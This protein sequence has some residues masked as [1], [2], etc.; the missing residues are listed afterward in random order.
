ML[1]KKSGLTYEDIRERYEHFRARCLKP[2]RKTVKYYNSSKKMMSMGKLEKGCTVPLY[3]EKSKC[4][5]K[6]VPDNTE[7]ESL[8]IDKRCIKRKLFNLENESSKLE[9]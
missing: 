3:G 7:C 1:G 6:I 2:S 5:L 8:E 4:V 9:P